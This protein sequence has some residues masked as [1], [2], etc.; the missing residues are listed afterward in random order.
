MVL[1]VLY[2]HLDLQYACSYTFYDLNISA[3]IKCLVA[4]KQVRKWREFIK[5]MRTKVTILN[6]FKVAI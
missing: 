4:N 2:V 5:E 1:V 3:A 6:L